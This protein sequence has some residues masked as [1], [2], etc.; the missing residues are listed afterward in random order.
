MA[1]LAL[2]STMRWLLSEEELMATQDEF[3]RC[4]ECRAQVR[5]CTQCGEPL[6]HIYPVE[7]A[8][9]GKPVD[10]CPSCGHTFHASTEEVLD[11]AEKLVAGIEE[12][13]GE[14]GRGTEE[15]GR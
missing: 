8:S 4:P 7:C 1:G 10:Y 15:P 6:P 3:W 14:G 2:A 9:C 11:A 12:L 5:H 13:A